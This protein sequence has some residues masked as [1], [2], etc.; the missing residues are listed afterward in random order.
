MVAVR[1]DAHLAASPGD[2]GGSITQQS[3]QRLLESDGYDVADAAVEATGL[4]CSRRF[5]VPVVLKL[6]RRSSYAG[7]FSEDLLES[8]TIALLE[9]GTDDY[10]STPSLTQSC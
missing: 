2:R 5:P 9:L 8:D 7:R 1:G 6:H 4:E 3:L 10:V